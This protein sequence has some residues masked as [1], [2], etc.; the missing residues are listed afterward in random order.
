MPGG[1]WCPRVILSGRAT[2]NS[3]CGSFRELADG[4]GKQAVFHAIG[5]RH[6]PAYLDMSPTLLK[7][8][9]IARVD[10]SGFSLEVPH[11]KALRY[12]VSQTV[13]RLISGRVR[14]LV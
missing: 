14:G 12:A 3:C 6:L 2:G 10:L 5:T 11:R 8:G 4:L 13:N 1:F 9:E 7:I